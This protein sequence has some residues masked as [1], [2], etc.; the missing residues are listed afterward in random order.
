MFETNKGSSNG[1]SELDTLTKEV[2][3]KGEGV[4]IEIKPIMVPK[5]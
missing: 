2:L 1:T 4:D 5:K 3:S